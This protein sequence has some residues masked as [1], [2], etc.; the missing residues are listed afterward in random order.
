VDLIV[1]NINA[2]VSIA[3]APEFARCLAPGGPC[4]AS[5][6]EIWESPNVETAMERAGGTVERQMTKGQWRALIVTFGR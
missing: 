6:F 3:L 4:V 2:P 5:G 1:T